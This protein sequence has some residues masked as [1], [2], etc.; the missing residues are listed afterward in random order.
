M[1][2]CQNLINCTLV[3]MAEY[4]LIAK[5]VN[6]FFEQRSWGAQRISIQ[7]KFSFGTW[8]SKRKSMIYKIATLNEERNL[9]GRVFILRSKISVNCNGIKYYK[10]I[11]VFSTVFPSYSKFRSARQNPLCSVKKSKSNLWTVVHKESPLGGCY[12]N[13]MLIVPLLPRQKVKLYQTWAKKTWSVWIYL[14]FTRTTHIIINAYYPRILPKI[15][16]VNI[17]FK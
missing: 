16:L 2:R 4:T 1:L 8:F 12:K 3:W 10:I 6:K 17:F 13:I 15:E 9:T 11:F 5:K 14:E 7:K